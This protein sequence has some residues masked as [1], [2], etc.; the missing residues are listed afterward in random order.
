MNRRCRATNPMPSRNFVVAPEHWRFRAEEARTVADQMTH[1]ET[2]T[3]MRRIAMDYDRLAKLA[4]V[5]LIREAID[6]NT[7]NRLFTPCTYRSGQR[8]PNNRD[9]GIHAL[10]HAREVAAAGDGHCSSSSTATGAIPSDGPI[11][12]PRGRNGW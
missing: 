8:L 10:H 9:L 6:R 7:Y 3:I 1:E 2:R 4:E 12:Y 11:R 5:Q